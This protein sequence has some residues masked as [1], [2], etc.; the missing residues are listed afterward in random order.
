MAM[1]LIEPGATPEQKREI[2]ITKDEFLIGRGTDCDLRLPGKAIS[3]HHCLIRVRGQNVTLSDLG[4]SNG[5][6]V[7]GVRVR[8]Q[9]E[10]HSGDQI[11]MD[12]FRFVL[13]LDGREGIE[14]GGAANAD[15]NTTTQKLREV[16]APLRPPE[17]PV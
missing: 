7:N 8:S 9:A 5:T 2:P 12:A 6:F 3:R 11:E 13:E 10:L 14:W 1:R 15:P 17:K 16:P 4:S